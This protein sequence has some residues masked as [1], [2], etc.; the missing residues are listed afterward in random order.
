MKE[1]RVFPKFKCDFCNKRS[2]KSPMEKH[3]IICYYNPSRICRD[4]NGSGKAL[5]DGGGEDPA[6]YEHCRSCAISK[7][8]LNWIRDFKIK[9]VGL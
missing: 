3:E 6:Y 5:V 1:V 2:T 7:D 9:K 4:C 8:A